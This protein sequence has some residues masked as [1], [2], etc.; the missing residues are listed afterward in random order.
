M[1]DDWQDI[2]SAPRDGTWIVIEGEMDGG[3]TS[4]ARIARWNPTTFNGIEYEW[5]TLCDGR[6]GRY[7]GLP[8]S[9]KDLW[10]WYSH[11]RVHNWMPL[12]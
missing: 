4:S 2:S 6:A 12:P 9:M 1:T 3:D 11:G 10:N 5:Q 7:S 8:I